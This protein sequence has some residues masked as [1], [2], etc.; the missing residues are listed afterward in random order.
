MEFNHFQLKNITGFFFERI[1]FTFQNFKMFMRLRILRPFPLPPG[2]LTNLPKPLLAQWNRIRTCRHGIATILGSV[3]GNCF[4]FPPLQ[5]TIKSTIWVQKHRTGK[6]SL[7]EDLRGTWRMQT[8]ILLWWVS[9]C[10]YQL[11]K[12]PAIRFLY[13]QG[14]CFSPS[15]S[16]EKN[17]WFT[18]PFSGAGCSAGCSSPWKKSQ[19]VRRVKLR[20]ASRLAFVI[21][22][23][24]YDKILQIFVLGL[25]LSTML[26][27]KQ[28]A[29]KLA[30]G[31][32]KV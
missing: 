19:F 22:I 21:K 7:L 28:G 24:K 27:D 10:V 16:G 4:H 17:G 5:I 23:L 3:Q 25:A 18:Y 30:K 9:L 1:F 11:S 14:S 20:L 32:S 29:W 12:G 6:W 31:I 15:L 26:Q 8:N 2:M 13:G